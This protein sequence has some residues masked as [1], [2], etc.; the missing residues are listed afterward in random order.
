M[1]QIGTKLFSQRDNHKE[2]EVCDMNEPKKH[3]MEDG[4]VH[5][6]SDYQLLVSDI[7]QLWCQAKEDA[8]TAVN[9]ELLT[10]NWLTGKYI[11]ELE[12][13]GKER[14]E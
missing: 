13:G 3:I 9:T 8:Y 5:T 12:Q 7:T 2:K 4:I 1:K 6:N 10:S 14:A 11:V